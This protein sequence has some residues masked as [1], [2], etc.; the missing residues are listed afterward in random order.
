MKT[1]MPEMKKMAVAS[2]STETKT[3]ETDNRTE[4]LGR[5]V[6]GRAG[7]MVK[8][9]AASTAV[10]VASLNMYLVGAEPLT[11][12]RETGEGCCQGTHSNPATTMTVQILPQLPSGR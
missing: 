11:N 12:V 3:K 10:S 7:T 8:E 2:M 5:E 4:G 9:T 6:A 1:E